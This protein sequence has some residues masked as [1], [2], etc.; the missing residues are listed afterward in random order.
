MLFHEPVFLF[1]F[2]PFFLLLGFI[3]FKSINLSLILL[4]LSASSLIFYGYW[5]PNYLPLLC[6]SIIFN[7]FLGFKLCQIKLFKVKRIYLFLGIFINLLFLGFFKYTNMILETISRFYDHNIDNLNIDLPLGISFFTFLQIAYIVD[8]SKNNRNR[9][10]F[11]SYFL[12]VSYF[13]HLIAGPL[14]HHNQLIPQ[15]KKIK[16]ITTHNFSVGLVIFLIGLFKK[17]IIAEKI[18]PWSDNLFAGA[19]LSITP[20]FIDSWIGVLSF[21]LQIY[22]DFSA[23]SDMAIGLSK[24]IGILLPVNFN[25]PYKAF[26]IIDFWKRWHITLSSFLKNYLYFPLGG[27][28]KGELKQYYNIFIVMFFAGLWHGASWLFVLWG[29]LHGILIIINHLINKLF[30]FKFHRFI[31]IPFTFL[32]ISILWVPFRAENFMAMKL[33]LK[34]LSGL[35]GFTLPFYYKEKF[36]LLLNKLNFINFE[37][38]SL[39]VYGGFNQTLI[40][41]FLIITIWFFPNTQEITSKFNPVIEKISPFHIKILSFKF[42]PL[43][44]LMCGI[45]FT[46]LLIISI[47]GKSGE[48]IYFQF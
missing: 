30:I 11:L 27:S 31:S 38:G 47:E 44:G 7:Y 46:Y 4:F 10:D 12:F 33:I 36:P 22:F 23:Y 39:Y 5:N 29:I 35:N 1:G 45:I 37:Y 42:N 15:F 32:I 2:L 25:S 17:I 48:F 34:G 9:Y 19:A 13:P 18:A 41:I 16:K 21:S 3:I 24:M 28:R 43:M 8:M 20:T 40:I 14:V 26:S 6:L